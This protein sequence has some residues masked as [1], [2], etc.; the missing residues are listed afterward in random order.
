MQSISSI[1]GVTGGEIWIEG[2]ISR[3]ARDGLE[4]QNWIVRDNVGSILGLN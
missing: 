4:A 1:A 2:S 3:Q